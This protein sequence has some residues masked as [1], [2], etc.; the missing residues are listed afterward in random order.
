M[1]RKHMT[2]C[3][4]TNRDNEFVCVR[5]RERVGVREGEREREYLI[6]VNKY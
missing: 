4:F 5:E 1:H 6:N 2:A 3:T